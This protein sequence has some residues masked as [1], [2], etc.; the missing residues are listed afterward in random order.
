MNVGAGWEK[1]LN[2][3]PPVIIQT[4]PVLSWCISVKS[5]RN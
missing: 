4:S 3:Y 5:K 2:Y 1:M